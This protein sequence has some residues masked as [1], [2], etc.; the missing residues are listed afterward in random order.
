M[1]TRKTLLVLATMLIP[2]VALAG[3]TQPQAVEIDYD[4]SFASGDMITARNGNNDD[5]FIGCGQR[6]YDLG[7]GTVY[8]TGFCQAQLVE[9][10]VVTCF[11]ENPALL[12]A[13]DSLADASYIQFRWTEETDGSLTCNHI[14]SST[15]SFYLEKG[16]KNK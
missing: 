15:Q 3:Y 8:T 9:E 13:I 10:E 1:N 16:K 12:D 4:N 7:G 11:T 6:T 14:G 5:E 2:A